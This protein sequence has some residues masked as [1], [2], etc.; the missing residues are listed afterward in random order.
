MTDPRDPFDDRLREE[1]DALV[2]GDVRPATWGPVR[3]RSPSDDVAPTDV[4]LARQDWRRPRSWWS[5]SSCSSDHAGRDAIHTVDGPATTQATEPTTTS[6]TTPPPTEA[7]V[8]PTTIR[9]STTTSTAPPEPPPDPVCA[10]GYLMGNGYV[11]N[12]SSAGYGTLGTYYTTEPPPDLGGPMRLC[13]DD[14]TPRVGQTV[15]IHVTASDADAV[16]FRREVRQLRL[17][18][19]PRHVLAEGG[20]YEPLLSTPGGSRSAD[21][22]ARA[23]PG[24][25]PRRVDLQPRVPSR[26]SVQIMAIASA[27]KRFEDR[28]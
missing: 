25:S 23:E 16:R 21:S 14:S 18:G 7:A 1:L 24:R 2:A 8:V 10:D 28:L 26:G 20:R 4:W 17:L 15:T 12:P 13:I 19:G 9:P 6:S 11:D 3:R 5:R 22:C 27:G